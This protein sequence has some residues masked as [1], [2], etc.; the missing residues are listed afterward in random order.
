MADG[1][2]TNELAKAKGKA[3]FVLIDSNGEQRNVTLDNALLAPTFPVSLFSVQTAVQA[4]AKVT[5]AKDKTKL[6]ANGTEFDI[7]KHGK[8]YYLQTVADTSPVNNTANES[9]NV[10]KS[11]DEW[12]VTLGHVNHEDIINLQ[13]VTRGMKVNQTKS[14]M[15]CTTCTTNK[16]TRLSKSHDDPPTYSTKPLERVHSDLCGP[17][18]PSSKEG[19]QYIINFVDEYSSMIFIYLL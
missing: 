2:K 3:K 10:T 6:I 11:L 14:S 7:A 4:G 8:L 12:H 5:F 16:M 19:H 15:T 13:K 17:I 9:I 18:S 1:H